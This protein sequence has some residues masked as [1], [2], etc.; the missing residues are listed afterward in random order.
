MNINIYKTHT[1]QNLMLILQPMSPQTRHTSTQQTHN[2][3]YL[4]KQ[5]RHFSNE[6]LPTLGPKASST[7]QTNTRIKQKIIDI[8]QKQS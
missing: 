6:E 8:N 4:T 7:I 3:A 1:V 5:V 2:H